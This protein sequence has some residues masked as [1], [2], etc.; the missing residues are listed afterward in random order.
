MRDICSDLR[1]RAETVQQR[2]NAEDARFETLLLHLKT[3]RD[4]RLEPLKLE[5]RAVNKLIDFAAWQH[6]VRTALLIAIAGTAA[7]ELSVRK[8][9]ETRVS[10]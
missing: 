1:E 4:S 5:L 8:P 9:L 3:E 10:G 6:N 2:M 7:A